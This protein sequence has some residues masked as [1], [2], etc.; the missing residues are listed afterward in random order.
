MLDAASQLGWLTFVFIQLAV[1]RH[2]GHCCHFWASF[3]FPQAFFSFA[4]A[5]ATYG[6]LFRPEY[7]CAGS[8]PQK[9]GF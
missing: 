2:A 4:C 7:I 9:T 6:L 3:D 5:A 1:A 8:A